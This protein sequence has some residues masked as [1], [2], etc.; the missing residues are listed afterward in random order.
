MEA[1]AAPEVSADRQ[2]SAQQV[3]LRVSELSR[4]VVLQRAVSQLQVLQPQVLQL[5]EL[6]HLRQSELSALQSE[7]VA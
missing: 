6:A 5:L 4:P 2:A 7:P 3:V 1:L